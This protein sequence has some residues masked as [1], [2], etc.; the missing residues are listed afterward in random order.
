[1]DKLSTNCPRNRFKIPKLSKDCICCHYNSIE[2]KQF[3]V[4]NNFTFQT[5]SGGLV[6]SICNSLTCTQCIESFFTLLSKKEEKYHPESMHVFHAFANHL[7]NMPQP[8]HYVGHCCVIS[9]EVSKNKKPP[10][11]DDDLQELRAPPDNLI[12]GFISFPE[13]SLMIAPAFNSFDVHC[14]GAEEG[15]ITIPAIWHYVVPIEHALELCHR[16]IQCRVA[17]ETQNPFTKSFLMKDVKVEMPHCEDKKEKV[18]NYKSFLI[19]NAQR[20]TN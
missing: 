11:T 4:K 3:T 20:Y 2:E 6:C 8:E 17:S 16:N 13:Y 7:K 18:I 19:S 12:D 14:L 15:D 9:V 1:M 5:T 10:A